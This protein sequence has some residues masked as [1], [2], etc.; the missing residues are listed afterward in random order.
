MQKICVIIATINMVVFTGKQQL[1]NITIEK[2]TQKTSA[3][4]ATK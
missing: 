3:I 4:H 1:A 2:H